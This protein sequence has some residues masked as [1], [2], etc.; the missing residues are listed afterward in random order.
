MITLDQIRTLDS[1][2]QQAV[3][4][5]ESLRGENSRLREKLTAYE[6]K[7]SE[8]EVLIDGFKNDQGEI[9]EGIQKALLRLDVLSSQNGESAPTKSEPSARNFDNS[10][11]VEQSDVLETDSE[12]SAEELQAEELDI[13]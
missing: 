4:E 8:L 6:K 7:V 3:E 1:K 2:V 10:A 9:E 12:G 13:F 11:P 5:I